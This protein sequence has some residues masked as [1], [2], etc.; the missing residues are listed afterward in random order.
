MTRRVLEYDRAMREL[1]PLVRTPPDWEPLR[2]FIAVGE[3]ERVGTFCEVQDWEQ[4]KEMLTHWAV[5]TEAFETTVRRTSE[6]SNLVYYEI[7]ER[8][9]RDGSVHAVNTLTVFEFDAEEK[10]R[11]LDVYLQAP[12]GES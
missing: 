7:A 1:V 8:H 4:Y 11:H 2:E 12:S 6:L 10:I 3:F 9:Y 5:R